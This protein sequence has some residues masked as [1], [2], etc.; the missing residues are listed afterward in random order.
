MKQQKPTAPSESVWDRYRGAILTVAAV[1]IVGGVALAWPRPEPTKVS[2]TP[3]KASALP[4]AEKPHVL[5]RVGGTDVTSQDLDRYQRVKQLGLGV[6]GGKEA[7][8][9]LCDRLRLDLEGTAHGIT[10]SDADKQQEVFRRKVIIGATA[11]ALQAPGV[12]GR[13]RPPG[14]NPAGSPWDNADQ[15]LRAAGVSVDDLA[16]ET[17]AEGLA[18]RTKR[19][20][21]YDPITVSDRDVKAALS[22]EQPDASPPKA[23]TQPSTADLERVRERLQRERGQKPL[24]DLLAQLRGK[25]PAVPVDTR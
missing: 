10:L 6:T 1:A 16:K 3:A 12:S 19:V 20:L 9:E 11:G 4:Q 5:V 22:A 18:T 25:W 21:V 23:G 17:A 14:A 15:V 2:P 8:D 7:L 13:G 24:A